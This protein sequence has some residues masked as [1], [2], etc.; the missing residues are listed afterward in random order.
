MA[1]KRKAEDVEGPAA[2]K[3]AGDGLVNKKRVNVLK[4]GTVE[5]G[6]VVYW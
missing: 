1:P 6:P 3:A 4:K 2:K 5:K